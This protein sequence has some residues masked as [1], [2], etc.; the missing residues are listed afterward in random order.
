MD[1]IIQ[2]TANAPIIPQINTI[3]EP[4]IIASSYPVEFLTSIPIVKINNYNYKLDALTEEIKPTTITYSTYLLG[5]TPIPTLPDTID[6]RDKLGSVRDQ[7]SIG[8]CVS[9]G[10]SCMKEWQV[11]NDNEYDGYLSPAFIYVQRSNAGQPGMYLS[12]ACDIMAAKGICTDE[13]LPYSVLGDDDTTANNI[14]SSILTNVQY[15]EANKYRISNSVLVKTVND[16]KTALYIN[17]PCIFSVYVY[18]TSSNVMK[19][20][21]MWAPENSY[22]KILGAHCMCFV[23]Y[24]SN[25]FI[26]RNSWSADWNPQNT[27]DMA[28][29]DYLPF[30]DFKYVIQSFSSTDL[31]QPPTPPTP[32]SLPLPPPE[33]LPPSLPLPPPE[34]LP[35]SLPTPTTPPVSSE[36]IIGCIV[37]GFILLFI[38]GKKN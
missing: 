13:T 33:P 15:N 10:I 2:L 17:G 8:S 12:N 27:I 3:S 11:N 26:I 35:P 22:T 38:L 4:A 6:L 34:P 36:L 19:D 25:G 30:S 28:G 21:R 24:N 9:Y 18:G 37:G 7:G 16:L 1:N 32:P 20:T 14:N 31:Y 5:L 23:G 29:Y